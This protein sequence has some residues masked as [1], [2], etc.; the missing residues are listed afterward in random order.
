[1]VFIASYAPLGA[2]RAGSAI[3][4]MFRAQTSHAGAGVLVE[5][6]SQL[7]VHAPWWSDIAFATSGLTWPIA[8]A[9]ALSCLF[10]LLSYP[11]PGPM[12]FAHAR[13]SSSASDLSFTSRSRTIGS[14]GSPG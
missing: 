10:G 5:V 4:Y 6:G 8:L 14:T 9:L 13:R 3:A 1:M 2:S 11:R 12:R 7:Y